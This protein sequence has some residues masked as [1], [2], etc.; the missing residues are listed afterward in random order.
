MSVATDL[1]RTQVFNDLQD[2]E[3]ETFQVESLED[4]SINAPD[5]T[6]IVAT[7]STCS[8]SSSSSA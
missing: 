3:I 7:S 6:V 5:V 1:R 2:L 8:L 4:L